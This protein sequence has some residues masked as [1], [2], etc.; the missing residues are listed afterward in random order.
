[1]ATYEININFNGGGGKSKEP[2]TKVP[3]K[4][5]QVKASMLYVA[6][7]EIQPFIQQTATLI[8]SKISMVT[9]RKSIGEKIN[10]AMQMK[11]KVASA[12]ASASAGATFAKTLGMSTGKG[13]GLGLAVF[14]LSTGINL[15]FS[16]ADLQSR[17]QAEN[18]QTSMVY[19]RAGTNVNASREGI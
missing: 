12:V 8:T 4:E 9:G 17:K 11:G 7:K 5:E 14:T 2:K 18:L 10:F 19:G 15:A 1:M 3:S 6:S 16:N 13:V